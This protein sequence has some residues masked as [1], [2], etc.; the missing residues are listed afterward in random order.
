MTINS[1]ARCV[2]LLLR[3]YRAAAIFTAALSAVLFALLTG[4]AF[5]TQAVLVKDGDVT[6]HYFTMLD[7]PLEIL[8]AQ[9]YELGPDDELECT[10]FLYSTATITIK[11][12]FY[13]PVYVED[14]REMVPV[15]TE[16]T[17]EDVLDKG[18]IEL[19][20]F[21]EINIPLYSAASEG[22]VIVIERAFDV[23]IFVDGGAV[24]VPVTGGTVAQAIEEAG[25][26]LSPDDMIS[27]A[28]D[29]P[30]QP[31]MDIT[32]NR[33]TYHTVVETEAVPYEV[34]EHY[35]GT[36][37]SGESRV[38]IE[39]APGERTITTVQKLV[40]GEVES[41]EVTSSE[42]TKEPVNEVVDVGTALNPIINVEMPD[43]V[44]LDANGIPLNYSKVLT[45]KS[46]AYTA[47]AGAKTASGRL[48][49]IGTVAVNPNLIPYGTQ[50]YIVSADG[51]YVYGYAIA[52]DTGT[53]LMDGRILVDLYMG[54]YANHYRDSLQ[55]GVKTV[56][57]YIL[58]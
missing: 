50:L 53:A 6:R 42:I 9:G 16:G 40:D 57:V 25:I 26:S 58:D 28:S 1:N 20:E 49:T 47:R 29:T 4:V 31:D 10:E 12:A 34:T 33:V 37:Y 2:R 22:T 55:W 56:N 51:Q 36:M 24:T 21:D 35:T 45:G 32:I 39:G 8:T 17:V 43:S 18:G 27:L 7:D 54:D 41:E 14:Q 52:A 15:T 23:R 30:V 19:G 48:A 11:R 44:V 5:F 3:R 38:N 46:A 13:V